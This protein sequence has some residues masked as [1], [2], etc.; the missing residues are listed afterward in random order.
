MKITVIETELKRKIKEAKKISGFNSRHFAFKNWHATVMQLLRELPSSYLADINEFKK[1]SFEDTRFK[2]GRKFFSSPD[3]SRFVEDL[4][5]SVKILKGI[6]K[7]GR[8]E[9]KKKESSTS[10]KREKPPK[11]KV[12]RSGGKKP[13]S[14]SK[15]TGSVKTAGAKKTP[16][17][18]KPAKKGISP[19]R[20]KKK[21]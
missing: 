9:E 21:S 12:R 3:N 8:P 16:A 5:T 15:K 7:K 18:R 20:K 10:V 4:E 14:K 19:A 17:A 1:L 11:P 6:I 13:A 2:R